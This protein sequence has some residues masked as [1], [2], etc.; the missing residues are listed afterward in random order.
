MDTVFLILMGVITVLSMVLNK[1]DNVILKQYK[2]LNAEQWDYIKNSD[3]IMEYCLKHILKFYIDKEDYE[4]AAR[5]REML[6]QYETLKQKK[7]PNQ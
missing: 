2:N 5:C 1:I 3:A 4:K 7:E 6:K